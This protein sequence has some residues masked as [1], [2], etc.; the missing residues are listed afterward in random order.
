MAHELATQADGRTAMAYLSSDGT[1]WHGLGQGMREGAPIN[2]WIDAAGFDFRI[3]RAKVR[4]PKN[5]QD[6][7]NPAA[8][9]VMDDR[10]V[11]VHNGTGEALGI[12]SDGYQ[13]V[14]PAHVMEFMRD[15]TERAG[16]SIS[17]AGIL[18]GGRKMWG[19]AKIGS[20]ASIADPADKLQGNLLICTSCDGS[21]AT[22]ARYTSVRVVCSN[23]LAFA[24][25]TD[26]SKAV[27]IYHRSK[28]DWQNVV[29]ALGIDK[30]RESFA[31]AVAEFRRLADVQLSQNEI[32]QLTGELFTSGFGKLGKEDQA[33]TL[34]TA[35]VKAVGN[36]AIGNRAKGDRLAGV[37]GTAWGWLNAVTEYVDHHARARSV[38][39][40]LNSAWFGRGDALKARAVELVTSWA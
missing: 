16:F 36:L 20:E 18:Y 10:H 14:Q 8:W 27:K 21:M 38:D 31:D 23:T 35:P 40:R 4:F 37:H 7:N 17:T 25:E 1:P 33:R 12:V 32:V 30:A 13:L 11:L 3:L 34:D 26:A 2:E 19:L 6:T 39:N 9:G 28:V 5:I 29:D 22:E 15:L 24:R